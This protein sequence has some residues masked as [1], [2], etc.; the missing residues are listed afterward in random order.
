MRHK[1]SHI[2][3]KVISV[4]EFLGKTLRQNAIMTENKDVYEKLQ[5]ACRGKYDIFTVENKRG[6]VYARYW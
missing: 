2:Y 6:E 5:L 3:K 4:K 1:K